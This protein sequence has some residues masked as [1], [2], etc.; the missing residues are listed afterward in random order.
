MPRSG[1]TLVEQVLSMHPEVHAAGEL[2]LLSDIV[3]RH[4]ERFEP[5]QDYR[6]IALQYL[7]ELGK[8]CQGKRFVTDKM[9]ANFYFIG[10][11]RQA[12]PHA[13]IIH[14]ERDPLDICVSCYAK[15][16]NMGN[17]PF[18][19]DLGYLA[20]YYMRYQSL[21]GHWY[22][23]RD[24]DILSVEYESVV[25]DLEGQARRMLD[26]IGLPWNPA[27]ME[28]FKS[29]RQVKTASK[30]QVTKPIYT[31]S[32]GRWRRYREFLAPLQAI[33]ER[34]LGYHEPAKIR[35]PHV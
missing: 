5:G 27:C 15:L 2:P 24:A 12:M 8:I 23:G 25:A 29:E 33:T 6:E 20:R 9:P 34:T 14:T 16:F 13:K 28:F 26:F 11:I 17:L 19:Y 10:L 32:I 31:S 3:G 4:M 35:E 21:M 18:T 1:S 22:A 7:N 30:S